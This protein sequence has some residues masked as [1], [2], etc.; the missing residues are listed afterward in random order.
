[1]LALYPF[2]PEKE[3]RLIA[4]QMSDIVE[5]APFARLNGVFELFFGES[6]DELA[7][8]GMLVL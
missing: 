4:S 1:M 3:H 2:Q 8:R 5:G 6:R 7:D